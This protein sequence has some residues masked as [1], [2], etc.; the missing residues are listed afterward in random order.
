VNSTARRGNLMRARRA[1]STLRSGP[2]MMTS[3]NSR[4]IG[5]PLSTMSSAPA[6]SAAFSTL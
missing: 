2:G 5:V 6:A 3:V 4:S 1:N